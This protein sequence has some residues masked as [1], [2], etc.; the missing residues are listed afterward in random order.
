[1]K[2]TKRQL[3]RIIKEEKR[4]L[5]TEAFGQFQETE[6]PVLNFAQSWAGLGSAVQDQVLAIAVAWQEG[7]HE[8]DW[9]D[10]VYEQNPAAIEMASQKL[11]PSLNKMGSDAD[12]LLD[13]LEEA[14]LIYEQGDAEVEADRQAAVGPRGNRPR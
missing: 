7:G 3:R 12:F 14:M 2:T 6:D 10:A 8:P 9:S 5:T 1:M 4:K 11:V 13:M